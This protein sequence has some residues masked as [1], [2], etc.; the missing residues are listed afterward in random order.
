MGQVIYNDR[1]KHFAVLLVNHYWNVLKDNIEGKG[2]E[3]DIK[4]DGSDQEYTK[5]VSEFISR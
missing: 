4:V 3:A 2:I 1:S 5:A